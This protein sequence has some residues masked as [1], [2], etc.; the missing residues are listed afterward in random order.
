[1][2]YTGVT[3]FANAEYFDHAARFKL[4]FPV[5]YEALSAI[6]RSQFSVAV[7]IVSS[8]TELEYG[9]VGR[10]SAGFWRY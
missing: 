9:L 5:V 8:G 10:D 1:M 4:F 2:R 3:R 7:D 6:S